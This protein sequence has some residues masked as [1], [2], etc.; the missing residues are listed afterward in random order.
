MSGILILVAF[1]LGV[2]LAIG[3]WVYVKNSP[4]RSG[5]VRPDAPP[6]RQERKRADPEADP[7]S[8]PW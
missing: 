1:G 6:S 7:D 8:E 2:A 4:R 5:R 3:M